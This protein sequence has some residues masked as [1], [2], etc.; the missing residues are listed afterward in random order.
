M[1]VKII[2]D[3]CISCKACYKQCP[4]DVIGWD[5]NNNIPYIAYPDEC[6][7]CGVCALECNNKAIHHII[8]LACLIDYCTFTSPV[9]HPQEY[10]W[11]K[12]VKSN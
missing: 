1:S 2:Y 4:N 5:E 3:N 11:R 7:H 12:W 8:P 10:N 6:S 9:K